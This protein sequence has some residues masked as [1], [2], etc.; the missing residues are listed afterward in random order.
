MAS[1][2]VNFPADWGQVSKQGFSGANC[3]SL[4]GVFAE[5]SWAY[6]IVNE[7]EDTNYSGDDDSYRIVPGDQTKFKKSGQNSDNYKSSFVVTQKDESSFVLTRYDKYYWKDVVSAEV[8]FSKD[9]LTCIN[10]W[11]SI[12]VV[13]TGDR[14][15]EGHSSKMQFSRQFTRL[16]NKDLVVHVRYIHE[17][18]DWFILKDTRVE[19]TYYRY[20]FLKDSM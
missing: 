14:Y 5:L 2:E 7:V 1:G 13:D 17:R 4:N 19:D 9:N 8:S 11:W 12:P 3:P 16:D 18:T 15:T 6:R 20:H 10:G